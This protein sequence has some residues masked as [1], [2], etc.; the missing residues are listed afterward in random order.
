MFPVQTFLNPTMMPMAVTNT[1]ITHCIFCNVSIFGPL[2]T[3]S[4]PINPLFLHA[5]AY[6][7]KFK[8][9]CLQFCILPVGRVVLYID[10]N[11][12]QTNA[13]NMNFRFENCIMSGNGHQ[14]CRSI[15]TNMSAA[16]EQAWYMKPEPS[17]PGTCQQHRPWPC[18]SLQPCRSEFYSCQSV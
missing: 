8:T 4:T 11:N 10:G 3:P 6:P 2:V 15:R 14:L 17:Q 9:M 5:M 1:P 16:D 7:Q 12:T 18:G 13:M